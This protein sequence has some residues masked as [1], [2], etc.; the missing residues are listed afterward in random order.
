[1]KRANIARMLSAG[2]AVAATLGLITLAP[3][4]AADAAA[5]AKVY[6][7]K[8]RTCHG[9]TGE[10]NPGMAKALKVDIKPLG[11]EDVQKKSDADLK[12]NITDGVGKMKGIAGLSATD[13]DDVV[14]HMRSL[15]K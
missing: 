7:A 1:M 15:K 2:M 12:K 10:G 13:V 14:A 8:C 11:S 4:W 9:P 6:A 3:L 5:G